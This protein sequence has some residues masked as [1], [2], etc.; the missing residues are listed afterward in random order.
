M[1]EG[2]VALQQAMKE[3]ER[4]GQQQQAARKASTIR[5]CIKATSGPWIV[6]R[7]NA[8]KTGGA[9]AVLRL[10]SARERE[11]NK[12][13]ERKRR[14]VA[15]KIFAGLRAHGNY[16][17]PKHADHNEVLKAL[18][19]EAG[20]QVEEDGTI[21]RQ[22]WRERSGEGCGD[23]IPSTLLHHQPQT[24][25]MAD[26]LEVISPSSSCTH[27]GSASKDATADQSLFRHCCSS[28]PATAS[29]F[30]IPSADYTAPEAEAEYS[31]PSKL[32]DGEQDLLSK[33]LSPS[34]TST[35]L[36]A[37]MAGSSYNSTHVNNEAACCSREGS[38]FYNEN[39][40]H[41][42]HHQQQL[43]LHEAVTPTSAER[44]VDMHEVS[45]KLEG[46]LAARPLLS[47]SHIGRRG[48]SC[49][50]LPF[51]HQGSDSRSLVVDQSPSAI[52]SA[53]ASHNYQRR[54]VAVEDSNFNNY[55]HGS[56]IS[57]EQIRSLVIEQS[58]N[59]HHK[60]RKTT[61]LTANCNA[62]DEARETN[63]GLISRANY[64]EEEDQSVIN[65]GW[66]VGGGC[67]RKSLIC[68]QRRAAA[69]PEL[70]TNYM[71]EQNFIKCS[72]GAGIN[73]YMGSSINNHD[74]AQQT[75]PAVIAK[76]VNGK[77]AQSENGL[78]LT[79]SCA[80]SSTPL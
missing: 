67:R 65:P 16:C 68:D 48:S 46:Q 44:N 19:N 5:G 31:S 13:R 6:R 23:V 33:L 71:V 60:A 58:N 18:C 40:L 75:G 73:T 17:L 77:E 12:R 37:S 49:W 43:S 70:T 36:E 29:Q 32:P 66:F 22:G 53:H 51:S 61:N 59:G 9:A 11:N 56:F 10:P 52:K 14:A 54:L 27:T 15:A 78:R 28:P 24:Q 7:P 64:V 8:G 42:S 39:S 3:T 35:E 80:S 45:A 47:P 57:A 26:Q 69:I 38:C 34:L 4:S 62:G 79:L 20:W 25:A 21:Y 72:D 1:S 2:A 63:H 50:F 74:Q 76:V 41:H 55:Q 30:Y